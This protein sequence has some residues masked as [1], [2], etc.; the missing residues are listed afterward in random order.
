[1][2]ARSTSKVEKRIANLDITFIAMCVTAF[3]SSPSGVA[4]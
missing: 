3:G 2:V 1:M 4:I